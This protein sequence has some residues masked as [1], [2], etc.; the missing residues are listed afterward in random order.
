MQQDS[1][2]YMLTTITFE[3]FFLYTRRKK[4]CKTKNRTLARNKDISLLNSVIE[5][6]TIRNLMSRGPKKCTFGMKNLLHSRKF[7]DIGKQ[8]NLT[9]KIA[10]YRY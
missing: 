3:T 6:Q 1:H 10:I 5:L 4:T 9:E 7:K 8:N 2:K